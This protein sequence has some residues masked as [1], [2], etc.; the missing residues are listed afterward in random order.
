MVHLEENASAKHLWMQKPEVVRINSQPLRRTSGQEELFCALNS[1][2][3][4]QGLLVSEF[5]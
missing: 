3:Q 2:S 1:G 5:P 4:G